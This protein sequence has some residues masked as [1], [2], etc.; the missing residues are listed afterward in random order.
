MIKER[1]NFIHEFLQ[2]GEY[3]F[4]PPTEYDS[5][6]MKKKWKTV[7]VEFGKEFLNKANKLEEYSAENLH[8]LFHQLVEEKNVGIGQVMPTM[9]L[10]VTGKAGGPPIFEILS[11][12][13]QKEV[14]KRF[15]EA[16]TK[17]PV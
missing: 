14:Q 5:K 13:G 17:F 7:G 9:R 16:V 11:V 8:Q 15:T 12:I 4:S 2:E 3:F 10:A 6:A 1:A